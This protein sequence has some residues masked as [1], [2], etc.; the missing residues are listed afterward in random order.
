M[1]V[2]AKTR[3]AVIRGLAVV[4]VLVT[5]SAGTIVTQVATAVGLSALAV[6]TSAAPASA[7][8]RSAGWWRR[9]NGWRGW[10]WRR[11]RCGWDNWC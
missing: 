6:T 8:W 1:S 7:W 3:T 11:G 2:L 9:A 10:G 4:A 5:Y